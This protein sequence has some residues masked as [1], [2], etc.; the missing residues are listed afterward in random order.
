M[1]TNAFHRPAAVVLT[2][3]AAVG[4]LAGLA[5]S[6]DAASGPSVSITSPTGGQLRGTVTITASASASA[7]VRSVEFFVDGRS[8]G[9]DTTA[10]Y[11]L[12][13]D[14]R[15]LPDGTK[16]LT[17][18]VVDRAGTKATSATRTVAV[19]N[20]TPAT[21]PSPSST[22]RPTPEATPVSS[23]A[24]TTTST[25]VPSSSP[26]SGRDATPAP[27][28]PAE[29]VAPTPG[30]TPAPTAT[31]GPSS[32]PSSGAA[33]P[34]AVHEDGL[35]SFAAPRAG[36]FGPASFWRQS[37]SAAPLAANSDAIVADLARQVAKANGGVA[38]LNVWQY[39]AQVATVPAGQA[40][41]TLKFDDCQHK[42]Y[43]PK[44]LF[45]PGGQFEDVPIPDHAIPSNGSD[46]SLSIWSPSADQFW[47]LWRV[48]RR[49]DGW[50]ACWGGRIDSVSTSPGYFSSGFGASATGTAGIGG[51]LSIRD[52]QSGRADHEIAFGVTDAA[53][54][55]TWSWPAQRSDGS[56]SSSSPL[57]EGQRFRLDPT[58]DVDALPLSRIGKIVAHAAQDYGMIATDKAGTVSVGAESGSMVA[59]ATGTNPWY[60]ML[61]GGGRGMDKSYNVLKNF[62][63]NRLQAVQKDYGAPTG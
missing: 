39:T 26:T 15:Q 17:A 37:L 21:A 57:M 43:T 8:I 18:R 61:A 9:V 54:W 47:S 25:P 34:V 48:N 30:V 23:P 22:P 60:G 52:V 59:A 20:A 53:S 44:G 38:S 3:L 28:P 55:K 5:G 6:A 35:G 2:S 45:G 4:A 41:V 33:S 1:S 36:I 62:P 42:G 32:T 13:R 63:W 49:L 7:G 51:M 27:M 10:P 29:T 40:R 58:V 16:A 50:H 56:S 24:P 31:T 19:R 12:T 46:S 14:S 11:S